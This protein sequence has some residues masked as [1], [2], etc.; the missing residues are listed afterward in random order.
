MPRIKKRKIWSAVFL[1][2]FIFSLVCFLFALKGYY[3]PAK[4][5]GIKPVELA[6]DEFDSTLMRINSMAKL[7]AYCDSFFATKSTIR[8]Y[9]GIV[10][11]VLRKRF[12]HGYSYY[13]AYTNPVAAFTAPLIKKGMAAIVLPDDILKYPFAACSQQSI[14]GTALLKRKGFKVR[15]VRMFDTVMQAGHFA[16]EAFYDGGWHYFDPNREPDYEVLKKYNRPSVAYLNEHPEIIIAAYRTKNPEFFRR[17]LLSSKLS[18]VNNKTAPVATIFQI[19]TKYMS[20]FGWLLMGIFMLIRYRILSRKAV[21]SVSW[22]R[23]RQRKNIQPVRH[24]TL[25]GREARA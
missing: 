3:S 9:P 10:S 22:L 23:K 19:A 8:H 12:Y 2:L 18:A 6:D 24:A 20:Y 1:S 13:D 14:V 5:S 25:Q 17:L 7:E 11:E 15:E 21:S 4:F 16:Y